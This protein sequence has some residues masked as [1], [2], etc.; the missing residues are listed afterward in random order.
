MSRNVKKTARMP[1][2]KFPKLQKRLRMS[3]T[4]TASG[5]RAKI[6]AEKGRV[7]N[8]KRFAGRKRPG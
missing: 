4:G 7:R 2:M 3:G 8:R 5:T 1:A 6:P